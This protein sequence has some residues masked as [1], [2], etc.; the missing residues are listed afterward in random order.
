[1]VD[2]WFE[3]FEELWR[4]SLFW[5]IVGLND[6]FRGTYFGDS[7]GVNCDKQILELRSFDLLELST[8]VGQN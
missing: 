7:P 4:T 6:H 5:A 2:A 1:M 8:L 3:A